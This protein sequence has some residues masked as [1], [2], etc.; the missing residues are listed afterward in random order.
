MRLGVPALGVV[1]RSEAS[2][3]TPTRM[4]GNNHGQTLMRLAGG[5]VTV[6]DGMV[7]F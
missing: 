7:S 3:R 4:T 1:R 5:D 2:A 6:G